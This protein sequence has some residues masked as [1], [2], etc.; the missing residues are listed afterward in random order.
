MCKNKKILILGSAGQLA[1]EFIK[2]LSEQVFTYFAPREEESSISDF[3]QINRLIE[4]I[5]PDIIINCAAYNA[6]DAAED[7]PE[8]AYLVN[9]RSVENLA[10][11]CRQAG[12]FL[13]H[14]SSDYVF[15]GGKE[16][17]YNEEDPTNPLN[18]YGKSKLAGEEVVL[19]LM[20]AFLVFRLSWVFGRGIQN[21][22]HKL[23]GWAEKNPILK[24]SADEVSIPTYTEDVVRVTLQALDSDLTGLYHLTNSGYASRYELARYYFRQKKLENLIIPVALNTF[25]SKAKRPLFTALSNEK[26]Q[27]ELGIVIP[28]WQSGVDR[29][30]QGQT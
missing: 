19:K 3:K 8:L 1:Q 18:V 6:V 12:I 10:L 11:T 16:N 24:I 15:D 2:V 5:A 7:D 20:S 13:V 26:L 14:F 25:E 9:F 22:L 21:F 28:S 30:L 23:S 29:L 17:L 27:N 4:K